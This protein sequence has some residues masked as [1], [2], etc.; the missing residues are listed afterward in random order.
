MTI[1]YTAEATAIVEFVRAH[2]R[3]GQRAMVQE[4]VSKHLEIAHQRG[5]IETLQGQAAVRVPTADAASNS[6]GGRQ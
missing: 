5:A 2:G 1:D 4:W 3:A 6:T